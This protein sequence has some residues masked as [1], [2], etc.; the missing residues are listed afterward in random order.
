MCDKVWYGKVPSEH[1]SAFTAGIAYL[2]LVGATAFPNLAQSFTQH[3]GRSNVTLPTTSAWW[4]IK[5]THDALAA[6]RLPN[7]HCVQDRSSR[8]P[9]MRCAWCGCDKDLGAFSGAQKKKPA[10]KRKCTSCTAAATATAM[11]DGSDRTRQTEVDW[12]I[13]KTTANERFVAGQ[14]DVGAHHHVCYTIMCM[15]NR[16][17]AC[18]FEGVCVHGSK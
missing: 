12:S 1:R 18:R 15:L 6:G 14:Y 9:A 5:S 7:E 11:G 16:L 13:L 10:T 2:S 4:E 3:Q 17:R 8:E